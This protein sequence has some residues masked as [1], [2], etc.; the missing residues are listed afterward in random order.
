MGVMM[1]TFYWDAPKAEALEARWWDMLTPRVATLAADGFTSLWLPPSS[2]AAEWDSMGY[3]PYDYFD[4]GEFNQKGRVETYFGSKAALLALIAE[5]HKSGLQ[6]YAD[7]V[8]NHNSGADAQEINGLTGEKVW[9]KFTPLSQ[10]FPRTWECF[11]PS[12]FETMDGETFGGMPDLCHRNPDVYTN[13]MK[14]AKWLIE[15]IGYDGFRFDFVLGYGPWLVK[16]IAEYRYKLDPGT[17]TSYKP[18]CVGECWDSDRAIDDW[19][20][21]VNSFIDNPVSAFDFPLHWNLQSLCDSYGFDLRGLLAGTVVQEAPERAVTFVDN[22]D[23]GHTAGESVIH[24]KLLAYAVI[25]T[26]QGYPCVFWQDYFNY[27][28]AA[29]GTPN[30][31]QALVKAHERYAGGATEVLYCDHDLYLMQRPG[32]GT[33]PGLILVLNNSGNGWS[34]TQVVTRWTS[35]HLTPIAWWGST[36]QSRPADKWTA[37]DGSTDLWA[38]PRGYAVYVT[39]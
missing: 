8:L 16:G 10:Q 14:L 5:A 27:G 39:A 24:D 11:H 28:L 3:D 12:Q 6:V 2:K 19:L 9:T 26:H 23:T 15:E 34:G 20:Q 29:S 31:I 35:T 17:M 7:M 30:G 36:D 18:F 32:F 1:Q 38:A 25:L 4:L 21:A 33:A 13:M 22:H 37:A